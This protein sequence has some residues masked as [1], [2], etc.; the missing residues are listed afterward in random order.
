[1]E[2]VGTIVL[3]TI[4]GFVSRALLLHRDYRQYPSYPQ[5]WAIHLFIGFI[6]SVLGAVFVPAL[7]EGEYGAVSFLILAA[8][9][10]REVRGVERQT[11]ENMESSELV[12]RGMAYIEGIARVFEARNYL[13][14]WTALAVG[15]V[16]ELFGRTLLLK[17]GL[18]VLA[19]TLVF[20]VL[21]RAMRGQYIEDIAQV[22]SGELHFDGPLLVVSGVIMMNVG[23]AATRKNYEEKGLSAVIWPKDAN[24]KATL[25]NTGQM[26]AIAHDVSSMIGVFMDV[27]EQEYMPLV[28]RDSQRGNLVLVMIPAHKSKDA[29]VEAVKRVPVLEGAI[30]KPLRSHA[31]KMLT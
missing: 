26:M 27:G 22:E 4:M 15:I 28:R 1:M 25:G 7:M 20:V 2:Y 13:A 9:Q 17:I 30:R 14:I 3:A 29:L 10:F 23:L 5:G 6:A 31:G 8:S 21:S 12:P 18:G 11:L 19:G 16:A 24:A